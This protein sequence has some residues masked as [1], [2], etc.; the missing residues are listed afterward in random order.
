MPPHRKEIGMNIN[1]TYDDKD[2]PI[3][4]AEFTVSGGAFCELNIGNSVCFKYSSED[5]QATF[6]KQDF[7]DFTALI[8]RINRQINPEVT[9]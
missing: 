5:R 8:N 6:N 1:Y 7:A 9:K 2:L 4:K 3:K